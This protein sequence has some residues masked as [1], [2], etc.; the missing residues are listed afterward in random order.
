MV[1][2][3]PEEA[4]VVVKRMNCALFT[5]PIHQIGQ[6]FKRSRLKVAISIGDAIR[7]INLPTLSPN[8][9]HVLDYVVSLQDLSPIS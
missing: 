5:S 1:L 8:Y 6:V 9:A 7:E 3:L 2:A 4:H